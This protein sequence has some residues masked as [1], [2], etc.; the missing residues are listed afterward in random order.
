[1]KNQ[2]LTTRQWETYNLIKNASTRGGSVSIEQIIASYSASDYKDG[3]TASKGANTH[4]PCKAVWNDITA[5]NASSE[6]EKIIII[7]NFTYRLATEDEANAYFDN[8]K[9]KALRAMVRAYN[10]KRKIDK[11]GQG[12]LISCQ[13]E[14]IDDDSRARRFVEAFVEEAKE[15]EQENG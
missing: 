7:D 8:L 15:N 9:K 10:V 6:V 2:K 13:G 11:D 3:Y 1:M 5:I 12:K 4:D 14:A